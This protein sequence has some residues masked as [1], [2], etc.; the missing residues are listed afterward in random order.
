VE[1]DVPA[2]SSDADTGLEE[3]VVHHVP[4]ASPMAA[5]AVGVSPRRAQSGGY[6][7]YTVV[8]IGVLIASLI[9]FL[10]ALAAFGRLEGNFAGE[11]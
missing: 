6:L 1:L 9:S 7:C 2:S 10:A 3:V 4:D 5:R 8:T 11:L